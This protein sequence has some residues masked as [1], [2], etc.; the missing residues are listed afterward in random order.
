MDKTIKKYLIIFASIFIFGIFFFFYQQ[1]F[2]IIRFPKRL[3]INSENSSKTIKKIVTLMYWHSN[4]WNSEKVEVI[5]SNDKSKNVQQIIN[6]WLTLLDEEKIMDKK[7]S[8]QSAM[9]SLSENE[10]Y[11][12]FDRN[13]FSDENSTY[14]KLMLIESLLK[15][16]RDNQIDIQKVRFLVHHQ[17]MHDV[18]LDFSH[19]WPITG[20]LN[21]N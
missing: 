10:I 20:F 17:D 11:L 7:A 5:W 16:L 2:I 6:S 18:H 12:S 15:T 13:L 9:L 4:R 3:N 1:E 21:N 14:E 8:L 19:F